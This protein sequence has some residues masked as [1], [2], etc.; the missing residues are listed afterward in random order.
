MQC[1]LTA[2]FSTLKREATYFSE[3]PAFA[4]KTTRRHKPEYLTLNAHNCENLSL[5]ESNVP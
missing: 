1:I 5:E 4:G 3:I 2:K